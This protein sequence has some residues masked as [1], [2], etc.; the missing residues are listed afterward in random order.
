MSEQG[1][2]P[3]QTLPALLLHRASTTPDRV[4]MRAKRLGIWKPYSWRTY[5]ER[6]AAIGLGLEALGVLPGDRVA[7]H[8]ENRPAWALADL[9]IQGIGA[10]TVGIYP[11]SP[12]AEVEYLLTHSGAKVLI[13]EDEEQVDK[14]MEVRS[15]LDHLTRIVVIDPR[16]STWPTTSGS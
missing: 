4:A 7:V 6:S 10:V 11:T 1:A 9:G 12:S 2:L 8:A 13:A 14:A 5:A 15:K 16:G 3:G